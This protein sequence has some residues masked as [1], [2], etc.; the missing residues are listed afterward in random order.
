MMDYYAN[1]YDTGGRLQTGYPYSCLGVPV[2]VLAIKLNESISATL[3][4]KI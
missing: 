4:A 3:Q 2:I 1:G